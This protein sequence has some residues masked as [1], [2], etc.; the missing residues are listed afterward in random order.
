MVLF[1]RITILGSMSNFVAQ[2][3]RVS[4]SRLCLAE[5]DGFKPQ[6]A[7]DFSSVPFTYYLVLNEFTPLF[8]MLV[9]HTVLWSIEKGRIIEKG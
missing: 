3:A 2:Q 1:V 5:C 7:H 6:S 8:Y 9:P 4:Y